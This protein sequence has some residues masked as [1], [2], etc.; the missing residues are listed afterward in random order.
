MSQQELEQGDQEVMGVVNGHS[1]PGAAAE[2]EK[3]EQRFSTQKTGKT[4]DDPQ[5]EERCVCGPS[6][7]WK[8]DME[9]AEKR[10]R[11]QIKRQVIACTVICVLVAAA[12][13]AAYYIPDIL[14]WIVNLG[15]L[16]CGIVAAVK[17]D[18]WRRLWAE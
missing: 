10:C 18:R 13:V 7:E 15:V 17:L 12:L 14:V 6:P 16:S 9:E 3:I 1:H 5:H 2:A 4:P 8:R 11:V